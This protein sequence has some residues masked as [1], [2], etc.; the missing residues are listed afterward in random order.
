MSVKKMC[1]ILLTIIGDKPYTIWSCGTLDMD[2][3][4]DESQV[5]HYGA[6]PYIIRISTI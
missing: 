6:N 5:M 4:L 2:K 3:T 1:A